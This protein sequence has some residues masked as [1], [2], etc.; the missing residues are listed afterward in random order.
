MVVAT[1]F[2]W[3]VRVL[4]ILS[5]ARWV[6]PLLIYAWKFYTWDDYAKTHEGASEYPMR[7]WVFWHI[8]DDDRWVGWGLYLGIIVLAFFLSASFVWCIQCAWRACTSPLRRR[9]H[10]P[11][12]TPVSARGV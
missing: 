8:S 4:I 2:R 10:T 7:S 5:L 1:A 6:V 12:Y 3:I 11:G 9:P